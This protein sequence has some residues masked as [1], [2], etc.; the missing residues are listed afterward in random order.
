ME[1]D[2]AAGLGEYAGRNREV[3]GG[4]GAGWGRDWVFTIFALGK[5]EK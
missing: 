3:L 1:I 5:R 4:I 2:C